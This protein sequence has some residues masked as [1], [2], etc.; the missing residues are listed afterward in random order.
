MERLA[1]VV[2][3]LFLLESCTDSTA[4]VT[5]PELLLPEAGAVLDNGCLGHTDLQ[6]WSFDW[7]DVPDAI[8]YN[9]WVKGANASIPAINLWVTESEYS[10]S[11][12][13]YVLD[14]NR[15]G[16]RWKVRARN[17]EGRGKWTPVRYFDVEPLDTD[18][19]AAGLP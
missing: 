9:I 8:D 11:E 17:G 18:C 3:S 14:R 2:V 7:T 13:A 19:P 6:E 5:R 10:R 15:I 1:L 16:W 4:P 12:L